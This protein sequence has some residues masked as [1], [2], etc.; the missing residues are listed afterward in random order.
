MLVISDG[1]TIVGEGVG[2][3]LDDGVPVGAV[4]G[5]IVVG[6]GVGSLNENVAAQVELLSITMFV[7]E[8]VVPNTQSAPQPLDTKCFL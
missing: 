1:G 8:L 7:E 4:G 6:E 3:P 2:V 5:G